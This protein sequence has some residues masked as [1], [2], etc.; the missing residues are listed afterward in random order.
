[1]TWLTEH[2]VSQERKTKTHC[3][4]FVCDLIRLPIEVFFIKRN[5]AITVFKRKPSG[6]LDLSL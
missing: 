2:C 3:Q 5:L 4:K 1:M 6:V